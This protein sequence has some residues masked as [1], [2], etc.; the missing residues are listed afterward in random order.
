MKDAHVPFGELALPPWRTALRRAMLA[1]PTGYAGKHLRSVMRRVILFGRSGPVD[2]DDIG[3][4]RMRLHHDDNLADKYILT[5]GKR[6]DEPE[7]QA[8]AVCLDALWKNGR[9][10]VLA[11]VGANNGSYSLFLWARARERNLPFHALAIEADRTN[12]NRLCFNIEASG[13]GEAIAVEPRAVSDRRESVLMILD[14]S[15]RGGIHARTAGKNDKDIVEA[16]PLAQLLA[17]HALRPDLM[18][19]DLE[20]RD[21]AVL[22]KYFEDTPDGDLPTLIATEAVGEGQDVMEALLAGAGYVIFKRTKTNV[23]ALR[24]GFELAAG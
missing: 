23:I 7:L 5:Y 8:F 1:M 15:N 2:I 22:T 20:G 10:P 18:K 11:D 9:E 4:A 3:T 14:P 16:L 17:D 12:R 24:R 6:F 21:L 19:I 13:A